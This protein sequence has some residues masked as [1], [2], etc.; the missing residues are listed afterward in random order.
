MS[1][2]NQTATTPARPRPDLARD[3]ARCDMTLSLHLAAPRV[4][5]FAPLAVA[6]AQEGAVV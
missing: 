6:K 3:L 2:E 1:S 4:R 5:P